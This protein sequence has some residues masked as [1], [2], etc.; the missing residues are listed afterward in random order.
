VPEGLSFTPSGTFFHPLHGY[1]FALRDGRLRVAGEE[2]CKGLRRYE[3]C[4]GK[5]ISVWSYKHYLRSQAQTFMNRDSYNRIAQV[6]SSARNRFFGREREYIDAVL[7]A[8]PIGSTILDLGCGTGYPMAEYIASKGRHMLGVD[9]SE[10][11]L[12]IARQNLPD[13]KWVLSTMEAYEPQRGYQG[14]LIWDS[15]FHILRAEHEPIVRKVVHGLPPGGRFMVTV[16]GSAH[17]AFTDFMYGEEFYYDSH[18]PEET[19]QLLDRLGC[20][21]VIAEYMNRPNG[22]SDKGRYAIVAEK[23]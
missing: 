2:A 15:L 13:E 12:E 1:Q 19:E 21:L 4:T 16:G 22:A 5:P 18:T 3:V 8:A 6:W 17:P 23:S 7:S 9:Q 10:A 14:A 20:R 11:M